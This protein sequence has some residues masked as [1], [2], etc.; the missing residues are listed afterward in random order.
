M[1]G[2]QTF[3]I[4]AAQ[5]KNI[6]SALSGAIQ[7]G[8]AGFELARMDFNEKNAREIKALTEE[9]LVPVFSIQVK[10]KYVFG[11]REGVARFC[12]ITGCSRVVISMLPF[13]CILGEERRFFDFI[14]SLDRETEAYRK[15]GLTLGYHHHNWEYVS[16]STGKRRMDELL[17][18][19][20][21]IKIVHDTYWTA[22]C[23]IDPAREVE[24]FSGRLLGVH[25]R[26]L[27]LDRKGLSVPSRD[28]VIGEGVL[29]FKR[30]IP[31]A[32]AAGAEYFVVEQKTKTPER[33]I[34]RSFDYLASLGV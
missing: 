12:E 29:D 33:D 5:R 17:E 22:K 8:A 26:D 14:S 24:R 1:F 9:T 30:I 2:L 18:R 25:L 15:M 19:T 32:R 6:T 23:G 31:A 20:E 13:D 11:D 4:R 7:L 34:K 28:C 21:K 16:L 27:T 3:T 10:P